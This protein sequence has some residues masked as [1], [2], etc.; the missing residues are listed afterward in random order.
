LQDTNQG[1]FIASGSK[2]SHYFYKFSSWKA[3]N[4]SHCYNLYKTSNSRNQNQL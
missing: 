1:C 2:C 3:N 4:S